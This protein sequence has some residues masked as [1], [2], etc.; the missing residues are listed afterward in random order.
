MGGRAPILHYC[1]ENWWEIID[2][3]QSTIDSP[4]GKTAYAYKGSPGQALET[5]DGPIN[6]VTKGVALKLDY[7]D[8]RN[9]SPITTLLP[10]A[11]NHNHIPYT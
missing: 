5:V 2:N 3:E 6:A 7:T 1:W 8:F 4:V 11:R 10:V 9:P